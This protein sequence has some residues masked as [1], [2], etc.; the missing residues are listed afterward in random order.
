M[1]EDYSRIM[2]MEQAKCLGCGTIE[3]CLEVGVHNGLTLACE[4]C[5][6]MIFKN[7]RQAIEN[8]HETD[9]N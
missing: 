4:K 3:L 2:I 8:R 6:A 1:E 5:I 9:K 7:T